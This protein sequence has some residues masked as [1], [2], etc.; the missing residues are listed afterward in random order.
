[1][2][3]HTTIDCF[4]LDVEVIDTIVMLPLHVQH[5]ADHSHYQNEIL[6][7]LF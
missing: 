1:M 4:T 3:S 2:S 6:N 5:R 7:L